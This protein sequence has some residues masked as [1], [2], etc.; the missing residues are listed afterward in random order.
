MQLKST[1]SWLAELKKQKTSQE[2]TKSLQ[3][4]YNDLE[5]VTARLKN[6][7]KN[8]ADSMKDFKV[9]MENVLKDLGANL[10]EWRKKVHP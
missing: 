3:K 1:E 9:R 5:A 4:I 2:G 7:E 10:I 8:M 6:I